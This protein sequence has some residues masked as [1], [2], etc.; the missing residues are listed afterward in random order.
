MLK[1]GKYIPQRVIPSMS[2]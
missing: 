1:K 2:R